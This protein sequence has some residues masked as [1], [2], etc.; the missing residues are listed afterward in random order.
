MNIFCRSIVCASIAFIFH[1][2]KYDKIDLVAGGSSETGFSSEVGNIFSAKCS[3]S[4]CHTSTDKDA[5]GGLDLSSW[6]AL[7]NGARNGSPVVPFTSQYSF[8]C[9]FINSYP[10]LGII[11]DSIGN[12]MPPSPRPLLSHVEVAAVADWINNG[13]RNKNDE[14]KFPDDASRKKIYVAMQQNDVV[15]VFD[16]ASRQIMRY[17]KVG[18]DD[19]NIEQP[20]Q[21][22]ISPDGQYWYIVFRT[23]KY[24]ERYRTIDDSFDARIFID[25]GNW[26]TMAITPDGKHGFIV[27]Y[28][29]TGKISHVNLQTM[30]PP[31][32]TSIDLANPHGSY[33]MESQPFLYVTAQK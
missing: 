29:A 4:G 26:N 22:R 8:L 13:A 12:A 16:A 14:L 31:V 32:N 24:L 25:I 30:S 18:A 2:C 1:S 7:F 21:I 10:D 19:N 20:H 9:Y 33:F 27:D 23:G 5:A 17:V 11:H 3:V 28:S 6:N 15:C